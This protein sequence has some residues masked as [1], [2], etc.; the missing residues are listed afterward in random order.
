M[1]AP[2]MEP[3]PL[4][5]APP[6][7]ARQALGSPLPPGPSAQAPTTMLQLQPAPDAEPRAEGSGSGSEPAPQA[8]G[9]GSGAQ[10]VRRAAQAMV[11]AALV[12]ARYRASA[13]SQPPAT[14]VLFRE[15]GGC[16]GRTEA[17]AAPSSGGSSEDA[18]FFPGLTFVQPAPFPHTGDTS[19]DEE[20][21]SPMYTPTPGFT[22]EV[23]GEERDGDEEFSLGFEDGPEGGSENAEPTPGPAL[24]WAPTRRSTDEGVAPSESSDGEGDDPRDEDYAPPRAFVREPGGAPRKRQRRV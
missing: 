8:E 22:P 20:G 12:R 17:A 21:K 18:E 4:A 10:L 14:P 16:G 11:R 19:E 9:G 15:S 23:Q 5:R 6:P 3:Q 1:Q 24:R 13:G 2:G 7:S